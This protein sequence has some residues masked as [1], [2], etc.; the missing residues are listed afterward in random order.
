MR[1]DL[2]HPARQSRWLQILCACQRRRSRT[3][4]A[5]TPGAQT[6]EVLVGALD[7]GSHIDAARERRHLTM[8]RGVLMR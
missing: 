2:P 1:I 4:H 8:E 7:V 5:P 3:A 6:D